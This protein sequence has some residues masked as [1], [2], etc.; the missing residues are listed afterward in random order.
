MLVRDLRRLLLVVGPLVV[1]VLLAAS[2]WHP[3]TDYVRSRVG[4]LL[5]SKSNPWPA[6]PHRKPTLTANETHY[7]I[8]SASTADGKYFDIRF[9]VDAYNPNIIPH[10]TFNNTWHVVA[11]LWNDPH[12][13]GFA[14]EFH[15]VGCLA[16]FVNDAMMC[17]GFV[18]NVSIE[19]T[20][21]GKCEGDI[22]YFSLNVGPHD[23]RV[24]YG[25]DYPLTIYGSNSGFTCFGM[26]IQDFRHLVEGEY[27]PTSNGDFAAGTE[28]HRPGT[29][30]PVEKNYFLFW[31]KENVMHVH[32]DIYPKRGFAKLEPD[33]S[34]GPELATASAEQD[35]KCL[36]RY[37]PK[38][39][40][41]LESIHQ[42]T[43]S[44]KITLCNRGEKD[45][46]PNDSNTFILTII[47]H[48]TFYDFHGEYEP[49]VVL[50]RQR[51]PFELYAIS[52][53]PLW[54][55]GR[56]RYEGRRT[57]MF[58]LTSV[59]WR[60]R[61]VNYHGYLDDV[62]LLGFGVEDKNSAGLDVVAGD[63][64]VDMGFCDES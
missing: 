4:A 16:Q 11:Q 62:V 19:P 52:K 25:P 41:E 42:A 27:K 46:E 18:Q 39:P 23:A 56:K 1:L 8:Y 30:R 51:A 63:L 38:M 15:E 59:N 26:W 58:Y 50:F 49:Y 47:Q 22:T 14:Q 10:Q 36:N 60:D 43:N 54:F 6:R 29:I 2:L 5:G 21:G 48:K 7:E 61:G 40:P 32:Y 12:S 3:R 57:D 31:D 37:L 44:L 13:N 24:F 64:L 45:C 34:T 28:I 20:P 35:E 55:H 33:G 9:G 17:I 53:K